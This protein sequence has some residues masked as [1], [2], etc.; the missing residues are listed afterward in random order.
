[1]A[2]VAPSSQLAT[3]EIVDESDECDDE[4]NDE[5]DTWARLRPTNPKL[6]MINVK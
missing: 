2:Q 4:A 1:M 3:Q 6:E 5:T